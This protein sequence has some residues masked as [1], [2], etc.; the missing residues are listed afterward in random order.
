MNKMILAI[1]F[2]VDAII[3]AFMINSSE[4]VDYSLLI[5]SFA[6]GIAAGGYLV[7]VFYKKLL[8][9]EE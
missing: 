1:T 9:E 8:R 3:L 4:N 2:I 7:D 5:V 6:T